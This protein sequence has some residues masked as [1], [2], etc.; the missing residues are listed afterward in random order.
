[1]AD[2]AILP[3]DANWQRDDWQYDEDNLASESSDDATVEVLGV[4][5]PNESWGQSS[6]DWLPYLLAP[7]LLHSA[8]LTSDS[9]V[10]NSRV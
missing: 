2:D 4:P 10:M 3:D 9:L 1:M 5:V 6:P 7:H 8:A